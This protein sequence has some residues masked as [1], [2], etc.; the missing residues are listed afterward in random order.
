MAEHIEKYFNL[1]CAPR[2]ILLGSE[3][4]L[5]AFADITLWALHVEAL[6]VRMVLFVCFFLYCPALHVFPVDILLFRVLFVLGI[7]V[8]YGEDRPPFDLIPFYFL[9]FPAALFTR[10]MQKYLAT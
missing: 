10:Q 6:P 7:N 8:A 3:W 1:F 4:V 2:P 9:L 5:L